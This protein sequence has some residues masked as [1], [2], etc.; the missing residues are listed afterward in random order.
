M[1]S[2]KGYD[3]C[4]SKCKQVGHAEAVVCNIAGKYAKGSKVYLFGHSYSC[5]NCKK[6]MKEC[7]V[8]GYYICSNNENKYFE[9]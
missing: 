1:E 5:D 7:G 9:L 4:I 8:V 6:H 2:G 3:K